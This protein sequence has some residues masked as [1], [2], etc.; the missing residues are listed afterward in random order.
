MIT[1]RPSFFTLQMIALLVVALFLL[2]AYFS[3]DEVPLPQRGA[4]KINP[5][6][7]VD[8]ALASDIPA[9]QTTTKT[10]PAL[11]GQS[12]ELEQ[13]KSLQ[14]KMYSDR[15]F[16]DEQYTFAPSEQVFLV[17]EFDQLET[18]EHYLST[19]WKAPNG[20][21]INTSR[22]TISLTEKAPK[23]RSFFWLKLMKNGF[24]SEMLT[25]KRYK[26]EIH[27]QWE[28]EMYFNG[29]KITTQYFMIFE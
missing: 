25:G 11:S 27:G 15:A 24:F 5:L 3:S 16:L 2:K 23:H 22:H 17:M 12:L 26:G 10:E 1:G 4:I 21:L 9:P 29:K 28:A 14:I 8:T 6:S 13:A 19:L 7:T 18:G 20:Q